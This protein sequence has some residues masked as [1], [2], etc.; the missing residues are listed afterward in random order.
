MNL[1][2]FGRMSGIIAVVAMLAMVLQ[3]CGGDDNGVDQDLRD[4]IAGLEAQVESLETERDD[5]VIAKTQAEADKTQAEADLTAATS[6]RDQALIDLGEA[7]SEAESLKAQIGSSDDPESLAGKLAA[8]EAEATSLKGAV[9]RLEGELKTAKDRVAELEQEDQKETDKETEDKQRAAMDQRAASLRAAMMA[10]TVFDVSDVEVSWED[11]SAM[12]ELE[13]HEVDSANAPPE[14]SGWTRVTLGRNRDMPVGGTDSVYVYTDIVAPQP[15]EFKDVHGATVDLTESD[16]V[17][18]QQMLAMSSTFPSETFTYDHWDPDDGD[19]GALRE[20][21]AGTYDGVDG[22]FDCGGASSKD[23]GEC[24][25][26]LTKN[27][28]GDLVPAFKG[29]W[30]F[31]PDDDEDTVMV[32]DDDYLTFGYWVYTPVEAEDQ[33]LFAAFSEGSMP[34][35]NDK[36]E[37]TAVNFSGVNGTATYRGSAAGKYVT[38]DT[39]SK[40][41]DIGLFTAKAKLMA[42]FGTAD[43]ADDVEDRI[44]GTIDSFMSDGEALDGWQITLGATAAG[45]SNISNAGEITA[46][47]NTT[48]GTI[49]G[50]TIAAG[51][52]GNNWSATFHGDGRAGDD[53]GDR[54]DRQPS[55]VVG[56]F[57]LHG[58][59]ETLVSVSGGFGAHNVSP[60]AS[61]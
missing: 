28:D 34:Y 42:N 19:N 52:A 55:S 57:D 41:A 40:T 22:D 16:T 46:T 24:T 48:S 50:V 8:A 45:T 25:I 54:A 44:T 60:A 6:A 12:V 14:I 43:V 13:D 9:T 18:Q 38:R 27:D 21:F 4:T 51:T 17:E 3:G 32:D 53:G 7:Q 31:T 49:G 59:S 30:T 1:K 36:D 23:S 20:A 56:T 11:G 15:V 2:K 37:T 10:S 39:I 35:D 5:A 61:N 58:G 47:D 26:K 29:S 33:H